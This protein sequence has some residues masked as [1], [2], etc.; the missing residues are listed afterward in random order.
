MGAISPANVVMIGIAKPHPKELFFAEVYY[1]RKL[2][3]VL[4]MRNV[5]DFSSQAHPAITSM[6]ADDLTIVATQYYVKTIAS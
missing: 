1:T 6:V 4:N 3:P 2:Q 5:E